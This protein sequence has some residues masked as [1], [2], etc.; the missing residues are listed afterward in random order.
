MELTEEMKGILDYVLHNSGHMFITGKAGTGKTTFLKTLVN[1]L[2]EA[3][4]NFVITAPTGIAAVNAEGVTLHSF[5]TIPFGIL[6]DEPFKPNLRKNRKE[7]LQA[8][9]VLIIDEVS[10][11]R[12]DVLDHIDAKL[13]FYRHSF[14][15]FGGVQIIMFGDLYQLPPVVKKDEEEALS[16]HYEGFSFYD[17]KVFMHTGFKVFELTHV[18]RQQ[19][20]DFVS[21]LNHIRD[22]QMTDDDIN[23][24]AELRNMQEV[25]QYDCSIHICT[26]RTDANVINTQ[27]L[28]EPT[29]TFA[30]KIEGDFPVSAMP[31]EEV[32]GLRIGARVMHLIN[33]P[34][35]N[36]SN[37]STGTVLDITPEGI[38]V[39]FDNEE[40]CL[41]THHTWEAVEYKTK[42]NKLQSVTKGKCTQLPLALAW[43]ITIHKSQ[44]L[45][46]D[47]AVIHIRNIFCP[48][49]LYVALSRCRTMKRIYLDTFVKP[50]HLLVDKALQKFE[51]TYKNNDYYYQRHEK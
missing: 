43:A 15:P 22:C 4:K 42:G 31:C 44:G 25:A 19:D 3:N 47:S 14:E 33:K 39:K 11:V 16:K 9:N 45:T 28:G 10:M 36:I 20:E 51:E 7:I 38:L 48:G 6:C 12:P 23:S 32:I 21:I 49:Q 41:V 2:Q 40:T 35:S 30:A 29:H 5:F 26:H 24:L 34:Q 18:F 17:A 37:G 27:K 1:A 46:F 13:K 50:R 8:L